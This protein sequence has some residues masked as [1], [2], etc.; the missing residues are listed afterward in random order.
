MKYWLDEGGKVVGPYSLT[1]VQQMIDRGLLQREDRVCRNGETEWREAGEMRE[2]DFGRNA[3]SPVSSE[4]NREIGG[5]RAEPAP[6]VVNVPE[7][8]QTATGLLAAIILGLIGF[9]IFWVIFTH[10]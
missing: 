3:A 8:G 1:D 2:L 9:A 7:K 10:Q 5:P 6:V 4:A